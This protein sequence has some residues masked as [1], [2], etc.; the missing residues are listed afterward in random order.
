M[1][2][3]APASFSA[4]AVLAVLGTV[5]LNKIRSERFMLLGFI[6]WLF[7]VQQ[8]AEG[9]VWLYCPLNT[10]AK[11]I[12]LFFA[13]VFWPFWVPL[14]LRFAEK[15]PRRQQILTFLLGIGVV[16]SFFLFLKIPETKAVC[17]RSG[18][19]YLQTTPTTLPFFI[20]S[21]KKM[22]LLGAFIFLAGAITFGADRLFFV[23]VWCFFSALFS[24]FLIYILKKK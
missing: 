22:W 2:F 15:R 12:F 24:L 19:R 4:G 11:N 16:V 5:L 1:C 8:I 9:F 23:S 6:P 18:I 21:V 7:A 3:S 20:S 14:S 13:Y 10:F 17:Y